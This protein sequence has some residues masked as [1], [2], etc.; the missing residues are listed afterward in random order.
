VIGCQVGNI[1]GRLRRQLTSQVQTLYQ[2]YS[3]TCY[4]PK[5][6]DIAFVSHAK[7][8]DDIIKLCTTLYDAASEL[9]IS[10]GL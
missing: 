9:R 1:N 5:I 7:L 10:F 2:S 4:F 8:K 3:E 6:L